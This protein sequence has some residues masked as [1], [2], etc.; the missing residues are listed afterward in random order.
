MTC[1]NCTFCC[2]TM[3]VAELDKPAH[4]WCKFR[5]PTNKRS[6]IAGGCDIYNDRPASC[7]NFIC[8]YLA[9][10]SSPDPKVRMPEAFRP[11][12]SRCMIVKQEPHAV[13]VFCS[14]SEPLAFQRQP[15]WDVLKM[16]AIQ[17]KVYS[18]SGKRAFEIL[19]PHAGAEF[20]EL[21]PDEFIIDEVN[22]TI[23]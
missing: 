4:E 23:R 20:R 8:Y 9:T 12:N 19:A 7:R 6:L 2:K 13:I 18:I 16:R 21:P 15:M 10:Q 3:S 22:I 1:G 11:D 17:A 14:P 5:R